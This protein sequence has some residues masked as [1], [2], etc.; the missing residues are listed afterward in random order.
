MSA[1]LGLY[2]VSVEGAAG[3]FERPTCSAVGREKP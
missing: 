2:C 3:V 1:E